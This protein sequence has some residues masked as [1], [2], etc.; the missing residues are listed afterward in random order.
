MQGLSSRRCDFVGA[1]QVIGVRGA[2]YS[3]LVARAES[4]YDNA[5]RKVWLLCAPL[6]QSL[7]HVSQGKGKSKTE[8]STAPS[9]SVKRPWGGENNSLTCASCSLVLSPFTLCSQAPAQSE[10]KGMA[11]ATP[12]WPRAARAK[13]EA[14]GTA[15]ATTWPETALARSID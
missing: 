11:R 1:P 2:A 7:Q 3:T 12:R 10:Q 14:A 13:V 5:S 15:E 6:A 8:P 4:L 9:S